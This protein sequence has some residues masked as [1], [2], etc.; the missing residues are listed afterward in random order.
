MLTEAERREGQMLFFSQLCS[1]LYSLLT[2]VG[3]TDRA[4][5]APSPFPA[6]PK[7]L[8]AVTGSPDPLGA[9][10]AFPAPQHREHPQLCRERF[11]PSSSASTDTFL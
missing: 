9:S 4:A 8:P 11:S 1:Q 6:S 7:G 2:L 10:S 5:E 3:S